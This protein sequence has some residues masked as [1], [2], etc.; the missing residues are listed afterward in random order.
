MKIHA[1]WVN[2]DKSFWTYRAVNEGNCERAS[3]TEPV[4]LLFDRSLQENEIILIEHFYYQKS[5]K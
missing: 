5:I 4:K 3:G 2:F 1:N